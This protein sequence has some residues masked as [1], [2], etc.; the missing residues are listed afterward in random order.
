MAIIFRIPFRG[1]SNQTFD[2]LVHLN[3]FERRGKFI[4]FSNST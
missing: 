3:K 2:L 1:T 4:Y